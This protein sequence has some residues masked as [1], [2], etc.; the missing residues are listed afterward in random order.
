MSYE[1]PNCLGMWSI[2][3]AA[4]GATDTFHT[5][6]VISKP[7]ETSVSSITTAHETLGLSVCQGLLW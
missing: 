5:H 7:N 1:L 6:L 4:A 3:I 2:K